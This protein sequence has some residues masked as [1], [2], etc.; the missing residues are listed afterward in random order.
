VQA[1][2]HAQAGRAVD[3][4]ALIDEALEIAGRGAGMTLLPEFQLLKG[5]LL[6]ALPGA[7]AANPMP[8]FQRAFDVAEGLDARMSQLRAAVRL[9][10]LWR[11]QDSGEQGGRVLR[12]V[13]DTFTEGFTTADVTEARVLLD[14]LS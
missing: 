2:A 1:G 14:S 7:D 12:A 5:D 4:L 11:D 10:R 8:W 3:G 9:C 6:L 13:Y